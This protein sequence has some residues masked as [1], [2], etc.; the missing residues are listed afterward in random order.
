MS[1]YYDPATG[2]FIS[3]DTVKYLDPHSIHGLNL[4][5]YCFNNPVMGF[6]PTGHDAIVVVEHTGLPILGHIE[7]YVQDKSGTWYNTEYLD[8]GYVYYKIMSAEDMT[9]AGM[10]AAHGKYHQKVTI[11]GDYSGVV[12]SLIK[13]S[14]EDEEKNGILT[15]RKYNS[16]FGKYNLLFNS[17]QTY[18]LTIL[19][20]GKKVNTAVNKYIQS[21]RAGITAIPS[22]FH[23]NLNAEV[24][25]AAGNR[26]PM[27][28]LHNGLS[29]LYFAFGLLVINPI[30]GLAVAGFYLHHHIV[31]G[32]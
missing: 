15:G 16:S 6:D 3:S 9:D 22:V 24:E 7:V 2:R 1:R 5:A 28:D 27:K 17:C 20:Q 32:G 23:M 11:K 26:Q 31:N 13:Q 19:R 21:P 8:N 12:D 4:Y 25:E 30:F 10:R 18:A 14:W 29:A